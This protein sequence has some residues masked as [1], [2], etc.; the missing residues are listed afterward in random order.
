MFFLAFLLVRSSLYPAR[1]M[2]MNKQPHNRKIYPLI[3]GGGHG[4]K[5]H[6]RRGPK[7]DLPHPQMRVPPRPPSPL[8]VS[9]SGTPPVLKTNPL[10][11]I[12]PLP[13]QAPCRPTLGGGRPPCGGVVGVLLRAGGPAGGWRRRPGDLPVTLAA[14]QTVPVVFDG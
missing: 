10:S 2:K 11:W 14:D 8:V 7:I 4:L 5:G 12:P 13:H 1:R 3:G 9:E 6:G